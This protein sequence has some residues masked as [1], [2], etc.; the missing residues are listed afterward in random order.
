MVLSRVDVVPRDG[1]PVLFCVFVAT[2]EEY[3][4]WFEQRRQHFTKKSIGEKES[5]EMTVPASTANAGTIRF[6]R[7]EGSVVGE[8]CERILVRDKYSDHT[9]KLDDIHY[10]NTRLVF[11]ILKII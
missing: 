3:R 7:A 8:E 2:L 4:P 11:L 10:F 9:G 6:G 1:K 5:I